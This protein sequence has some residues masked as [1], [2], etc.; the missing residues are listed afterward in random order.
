MAAVIKTVLMKSNKMREAT[1]SY[2]DNIIIDVMK[3]L[4][5]QV[6]DHLKEFEQTTKSLEPLEEEQHWA[7]KMDKRKNSELVIK[8]GYEI[9]QVTEDMS[10]W[11]LFLVI[12]KLLKHYP[13][14][15]WQRPACS[16]VKRRASGIDWDDKVDEETVVMIKEIL[17]K[18]LRENPVTGTRHIPKT[19]TGVM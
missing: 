2:I 15:G 4:T 7:L 11:E 10:R 14:A 13:V 6:V 18:V 12:G 16:Y 1:V 19:R 17:G 8:R 3:V 9:P 5:K